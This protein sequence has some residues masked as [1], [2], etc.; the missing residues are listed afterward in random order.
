MLMQQPM[1]GAGGQQG[2]ERVRDV[3]EPEDAESWGTE[4]GASRAAITDD[5]QD[6]FEPAWP[7][8]DSSL[9]EA[10]GIGADRGA[11]RGRNQSDRRVR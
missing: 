1:M 3:F 10:I 9:F 5:D 2:T 6:E 4:A 8:T 7:D 11:A